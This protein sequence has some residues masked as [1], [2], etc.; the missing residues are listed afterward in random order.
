MK[1]IIAYHGTNQKFDKFSQEKA[2][3]SDD[4]YGGGTAYFTNTEAIAKTYARAMVRKYGGSNVIYKVELRLNKIFDVDDIFTG[5]ELTK[6]IKS[7]NTEQFARGAGLLSLGKDK[8][9][10]LASLVAGDVQLSGKEVFKGLSNGMVNTARAREI[11]KRLNYDSLRYNGGE[12]MGGT[13]H[14]VYIVYKDSDIKILDV[15]ENA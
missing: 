11:L 4:Y 14:D 8:Y 3:L 10:T 5:K 6:F 7:G 15:K 12:M 13:K 2:R 9:K 1:T